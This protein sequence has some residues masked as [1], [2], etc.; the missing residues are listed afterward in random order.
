MRNLFEKTGQFSFENKLIS[1]GIGLIGAC[2]IYTTIETD[3]LLRTLDKKYAMS[4][5]KGTFTNKKSELHA[6]LGKE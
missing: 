5:I 1:K 4:W 6:Y 2:L 3:S